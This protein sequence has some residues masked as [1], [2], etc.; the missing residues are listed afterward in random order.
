MGL[1]QGSTVCPAKD[2]VFPDNFIHEIV[3]TKD[4]IKNQS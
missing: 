3:G 1:R 2:C 4:L